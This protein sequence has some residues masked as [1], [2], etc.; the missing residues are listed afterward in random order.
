M[1]NAECRSDNEPMLSLAD[2]SA[3]IGDL[4][5]PLDELRERSA[6][7]MLHSFSTTEG[8]DTIEEVTCLSQCR[9]EIYL[10]DLLTFE[11]FVERIS[12]AQLWYVL[13]LKTE[14][15]CRVALHDR[16]E[17]SSRREE[18]GI[19]EFEWGEDVTRVACSTPFVGY[20]CLK[21]HHFE[22]MRTIENTTTQHNSRPVEVAL[23]AWDKLRSKQS[24]KR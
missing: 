24:W 18:F 15:N 1:S 21:L 10:I 16:V 20:T 7:H 17:R 3:A 8:V 6:K 4:S 11:K 22:V 9:R 19:R 23:T 13:A 14:G 5:V 12:V 2:K